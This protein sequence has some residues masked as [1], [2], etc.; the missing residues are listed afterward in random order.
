[1]TES[2]ERAVA[3]KEDIEKACIRHNLNLTIIGGKI[4]F[5]DQKEMKIV[6]VWN[7]EF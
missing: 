6:M 7:A 4:G 2:Q 5:V 3:L 1:M